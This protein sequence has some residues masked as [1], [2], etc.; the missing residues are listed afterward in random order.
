M[1]LAGQRPRW[2]IAEPEEF[3]A[4][5]QRWIA[6][7]WD[8]QVTVG[9]WWDRL[10]AA[11]LTAPTWPRSQGGLAATT[12]IQAVIEEELANIGAIAPPVMGLGIR[13]IGAAIR[14]FAT[15]EQ[16][17]EVIP[18]L[19]TGRNLWTAL[20]NEPGIDDPAMTACVAEFDWKYV[21]LNGTKTCPDLAATHAILLARS[22]RG[23]VSRDGLSWFLM[24]LEFHPVDLASGTVTFRDVQLL[25]DRVLGNRDD[26]WTLAKTI[27][28]FNERSLVGRIRRGL[29]HVESG[30]KAGNLVRVVGD[31]LAEARARALAKA[32]AAGAV[33]RRRG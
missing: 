30:T 22:A 26:G 27:L 2:P 33:D 16:F 29:V 3:R 6:N 20:M 19:L 25:H 23:S 32:S 15:P 7:N 5:L 24:D 21:T 28:P 13:M 10:A 18:R 8:V 12:A 4:E 17:E 11:G 31:V 14:Q 9:E 1:D